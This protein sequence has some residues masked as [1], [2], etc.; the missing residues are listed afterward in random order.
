M[1]HEGSRRSART[2]RPRSARTR[3]RQSHELL[4]L[5]FGAS[6]PG[7]VP[8]R[9][10]RRPLRRERCPGPVGDA[11][12]TD[13]GSRT[14]GSVPQSLQS[15]PAP[16]KSRALAQGTR[17]WV[18]RVLVQSQVQVPPIGTLSS[19]TIRLLSAKHGN[20]VGRS[21]RIG[22]ERAWS[23]QRAHRST[24]TAHTHRAHGS[25]RTAHREHMDSTWEHT[26]SAQRAHGNTREHTAH[27]EHT[28]STREHT[29]STQRAHRS[30][31]AAHGEHTGAH[32]PGAGQAPI[33]EQYLPGLP[34]QFASKG[35]KQQ[36]TEAEH[37]QAV[38]EAA[39]APQCRRRPLVLNPNPQ[40]TLCGS[41]WGT[42]GWRT[43][44]AGRA[45]R[46]W[47]E[48]GDGGSWFNSG[49]NSTRAD[50]PGTR[51]PSPPRPQ[52]EE[53]FTSCSSSPGHFGLVL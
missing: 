2:E 1:T 53:I 52:E 20:Q 30:T 19:E 5:E 26:Y 38:R 15:S 7:P 21:Q 36:K 46:G 43:D 22:K 6:A 23:T 51:T 12:L 40:P 31:Q 17:R 34:E 28:D 41:T 42:A 49:H 11:D 50:R 16:R 45:G 27:R 29:S 3:R 24:R 33:G 47:V 8:G 18:A 9:H 25:T 13:P 37:G 32:R 14:R 10:P 4:S 35:Q 44:G 39:R 48:A